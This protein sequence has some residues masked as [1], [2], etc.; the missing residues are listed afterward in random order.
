MEPAPI[1]ENALLSGP[2]A[3]PV[4][5][6]PDERAD[7]GAL[8]RAPEF[9]EGDERAERSV[10]CGLGDRVSDR[11]VFVMAEVAVEAGLAEGLLQPRDAE[12]LEAVGA[13]LFSRL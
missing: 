4:D 12:D 10:P 11:P 2:P 6:A 5:E 1:P 7:E 9:P 8:A 3:T 13:E